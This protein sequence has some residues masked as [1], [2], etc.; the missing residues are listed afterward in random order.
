MK[1]KRKRKTWRCFHCDEVFRGSLRAALHFGSTQ[2][3]TPACKV[4]AVIFR[5]LELELAKYRA[6]DTQLHRQ[7]ASMEGT[8]Q[9]A[10]MRAEESG[11]AKGLQDGLKSKT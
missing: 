2:D 3:A 6:E 7:I 5:K 4:N 10:L 11:Y 1:A 9:Q 8:H